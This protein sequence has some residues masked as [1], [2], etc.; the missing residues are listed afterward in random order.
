MSSDDDRI[1]LLARALYEIRL[2]LGDYLGSQNAAPLHLREAAHLS[3]ALHNEALASFEGRDFDLEEAISK[4]QAIE[5]ILPE[6][7]VAARVLRNEQK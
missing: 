2:L 4:I 1:R 7:K 3:Y 5:R 6:S